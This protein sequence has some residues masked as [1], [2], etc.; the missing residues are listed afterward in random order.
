MVVCSAA[1]F[2][3]DDGG[4]DDD[5]G[6]AGAYSTYTQFMN[7]SSITQYPVSTCYRNHHPDRA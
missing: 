6:G 1:M 4:D 5:G 7:Q 3:D 2:S